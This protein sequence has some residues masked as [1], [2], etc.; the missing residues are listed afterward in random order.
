MDAPYLVLEPRGVAVE[1]DE[2]RFRPH[3]QMVI[4][5]QLFQQII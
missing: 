3:R 5:V 1:R 2:L 4:L